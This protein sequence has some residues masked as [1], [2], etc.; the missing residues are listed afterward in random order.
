MVL[1]EARI[2]PIGSH[3]SMCRLEIAGTCH[4]HV[5]SSR[6]TS[7]GL[8]MAS[9]YRNYLCPVISF[10]MFRYPFIQKTPSIIFG[11]IE[12]KVFLFLGVYIFSDMCTQGKKYM[13]RNPKGSHPSNITR[14]N[15]N[16]VQPCLFKDHLHLIL[17]R[18]QQWKILQEPC[19]SCRTEA[20]SYT[21][22]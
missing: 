8:F 15:G 17:K 19:V 2:P 14:I 9:S 21:L 12:R 6:Y 22:D 7:K 10:E 4:S 16:P 18:T 3:A 5:L 20:I 11:D 1:S 13:H